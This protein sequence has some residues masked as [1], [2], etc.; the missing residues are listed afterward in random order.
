MNYR[1]EKDPMGEMRVPRNCYYGAQ[2]ARSLI[3]FNSGREKMPEEVIKAYGIIKKAAAMVNNDLGLLTKKK[4]Q[5][6]TQAADEIID[7]KLIDQFPLKVWQTGSGTHTNMNVNEVI[8]NRAI[9]IAG[10][11]KGSK[12]PIHPMM[13]LTNRNLPMIRSLLPCMLRL[14]WQLTGC[15]FR[16][17]RIWQR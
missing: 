10:G 9:E 6:I 4:M 15:Y 11:K 5:L 13:M 1:I 8:A 14:L 7:G 3:N 16:R 12:T 17:L 2:T